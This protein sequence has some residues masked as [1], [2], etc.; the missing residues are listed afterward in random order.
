LTIHQAVVF[1]LRPN[2]KLAV[3][4]SSNEF[5]NLSKAAVL[6]TALLSIQAFVFGTILLLQF[7]LQA[8]TE[9]TEST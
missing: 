7:R 6:T 5:A 1:V 8:Q 4:V 2:R 9:P 3:L